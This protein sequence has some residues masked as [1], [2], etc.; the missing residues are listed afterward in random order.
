MQLSRSAVIV[1]EGHNGRVVER[2]DPVDIVRCLDLLDHYFWVLIV[3]LVLEV[4]AGIRVVV[5]LGL[6]QF[7][8][9][10]EVDAVSGGVVAGALNGEHLVRVL[11]H[12]LVAGERFEGGAL[13]HE[14]YGHGGPLYVEAVQHFIGTVVEL[15]DLPLGEVLVA[16]EEDL[17]LLLL[18]LLL[19]LAHHGAGLVDLLL[20]GV[21]DPPL[22]LLKLI[23]KL[24]LEILIFGH[25]NNLPLLLQLLLPLVKGRRLHLLL[26]SGVALVL[27]DLAVGLDLFV[28]PSHC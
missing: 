8:P 4:V 17:L 20:L 14:V 11:V 27:D 13:S 23:L 15:Q 19:A 24:I 12:L 26:L 16:A 21:A 2:F 1:P 9:F 10:G 7:G 28:L 5:V 6:V 18:G 25:I 3:V 22:L